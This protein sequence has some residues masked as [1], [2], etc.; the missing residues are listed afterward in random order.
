MPARADAACPTLKHL[1]VPRS[2]LP[3]SLPNTPDAHRKRQL[4]DFVVKMKRQVVKVYA[5]AKWSRDAK[6]VQ[7]AMVHPA[8]ACWRVVRSADARA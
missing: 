5:I 4:A 8:V 6:V 3:N 2:A 7:K 1:P